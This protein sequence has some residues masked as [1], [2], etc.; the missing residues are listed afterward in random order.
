MEYFQIYFN[1]F[2]NV[3]VENLNFAYSGGSRINNNVGGCHVIFYNNVE[4]YYTEIKLKEFQL[5]FLQK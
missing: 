4:M 3:S 1:I 2:Y 5:N